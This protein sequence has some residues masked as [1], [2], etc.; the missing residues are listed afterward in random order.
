M[1]KKIQIE[2][3]VFTLIVIST[4]F[5]YN[6]DLEIIKF[7]SKLNFGMGAPYLKDFFVNITELGDSLWYFLIIFFIFII[8]FVLKNTK[9]LSTKRYFYIKN[10]S[11]FS[12][13]YLLLT[14]IIVQAIK[15][16]VGRTRPNHK[17]FDDSYGFNF[18]STDSAFHSF[19]SGHSST[20]IAITLILCLILPSLRVFFYLSGSV[21]AISRVVVGAHY[22]TDVVAGGII[23][24]VVYKIFYDFYNKNIYKF[25]LDSFGSQET[26]AVFK[27]SVVFIIVAIFLTVGPEFD[28]FFSSL[29]YYSDNQFMIQSYYLVSIIFRKFLLPLLL[30]YV[31]IFPIIS[32]FFSIKKIFFNYTFSFK[33]IFFMVVRFNHTNYVCESVVKKYVG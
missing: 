2:L 15:H 27:I 31:F 17:I 3:F 23:S 7:F 32:K 30:I 19:P 20:I 8:S 12:F 6:I 21:I 28:I 9:L 26:S 1:I 18:F 33:E 24:I 16:V 5:T 22:L 25:S 11:L 13:L 4:L 10:L 14:G 29:F